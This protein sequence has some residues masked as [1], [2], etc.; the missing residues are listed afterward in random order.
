MVTYS[1]CPECGYERQAGEGG[2]P[3]VCPRCGLVFSKW[4]KR[5]FAA[6]R[7]AVEERL[8]SDESGTSRLKDLWVGLRE[9]AVFVDPEMSSSR[10]YAYVAI[11]VVFFLWGW[12]F[13]LM[14]YQSNEIGSS[15]MHRIDLVFHEAGHVVFRLFGHFVMVLGG[16][17]GQLLMPLIVM[18][19]LLVKNRDP[20]GASIGLWWLAQSLMD[21]APYINDARAMRLI[22]LGG[23]TGRDR[24]GMHDWHNILS[25]LGL[26]QADH[27]LAALTD[28]LG[29][30]LMLG[31]FVWGGYILLRQYR[32]SRMA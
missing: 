24:P 26:L 22:L 19:A 25:S 23:G 12:S 17:L 6:A 7:P 21:L 18:L 11:Y 31:A 15:F 30:V 14:D 13:I 3:D 10:L 16:S 8:D 2:D 20:F 4:M 29:V 27:T 1:K 9:R 5:R 28:G 32:L